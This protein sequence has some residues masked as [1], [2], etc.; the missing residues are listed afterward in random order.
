M[1]GRI[2]TMIRER[3]QRFTHDGMVLIE[4]V[5]P[6]TDDECWACAKALRDTEGTV[7]HGRF[8]ITLYCDE[9]APTSARRSTGDCVAVASEGTVRPAGSSETP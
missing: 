7:D 5:A 6:A 3:A 2:E 4:A 1:S 8:G 9:C